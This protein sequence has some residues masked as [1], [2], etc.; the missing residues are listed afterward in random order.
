MG[1]CS[2]Y[3]QGAYFITL[4]LEPE[5]YASAAVSYA[6]LPLPMNLT[7]VGMPADERAFMMKCGFID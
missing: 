6:V 5:K 2:L 7:F 3:E 4:C 1:A